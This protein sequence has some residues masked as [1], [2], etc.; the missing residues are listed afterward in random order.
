MR[1]AWLVDG[2]NYSE[3]ATYP[4]CSYCGRTYHVPAKTAWGGKSICD[5]CRDS[6]PAHLKGVGT[7]ET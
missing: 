1:P 4:V 5:W 6:W 3:E 2:M 7:L